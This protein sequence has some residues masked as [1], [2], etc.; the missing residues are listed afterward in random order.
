[1]VF[2]ASDRYIKIRKIRGNHGFFPS[3]C[4]SPDFSIPPM[5]FRLYTL[6]LF[7]FTVVA[8]L[9]VFVYWGFWPAV[10]LLLAS[11]FLIYYTEMR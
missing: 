7:I 2:A 5:Q 9:A 8:S 11:L 1:M 10:V 3:R 4:S 6:L